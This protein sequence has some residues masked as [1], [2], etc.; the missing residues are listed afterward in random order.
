VGEGGTFEIGQNC[1]NIYSLLYFIYF[2]AREDVTIRYCIQCLEEQLQTIL[3]HLTTQFGK[4][5]EF[6]VLFKPMGILG[7][8]LW[9]SISH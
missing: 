5:L 1:Q 4:Y 3:N 6:E 8:T 7:S 9:R 2:E